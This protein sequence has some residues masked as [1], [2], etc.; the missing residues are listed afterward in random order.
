MNEL[1]TSLIVLLIV[2][3][4]YTGLKK[5]LKNFKSKQSISCG[6]SQNSRANSCNCKK[7]D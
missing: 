2:F 3:L 1:I 4:T 6:C 7:S 5:I